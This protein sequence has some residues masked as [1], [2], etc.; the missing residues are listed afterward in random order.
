MKRSSF[1]GFVGLAVMVVI[2]GVRTVNVAGDPQ[3]GLPS[4]AA[5]PEGPADACRA[6]TEAAFI[7]E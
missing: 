5:R 7:G 3:I 6:V 1:I 2:N 4:D